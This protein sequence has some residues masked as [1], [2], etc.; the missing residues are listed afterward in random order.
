MTAEPLST[1]TDLKKTKSLRRSDH[2]FRCTSWHNPLACALPRIT[3]LQRDGSFVG[4]PALV[5]L[6]VSVP[7]P[8][9]PLSVL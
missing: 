3:L 8:E 6:P 2:P 4:I 9:R 1:P 7:V 5:M